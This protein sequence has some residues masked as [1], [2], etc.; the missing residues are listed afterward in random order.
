MFAVWGI[1]WA[2]ARHDAIKETPLV[3]PQG[4]QLSQAEYYARVDELADKKYKKRRA[5]QL[6]PL[7]GSRREAEQFASLLRKSGR[8]CR[9][10]CIKQKMDDPEDKRTRTG[11]VKTVWA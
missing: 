4:R 10:I 1:S 9:D 5:K 8:Q 7:Y 6:S 3:D 11:K 2:D